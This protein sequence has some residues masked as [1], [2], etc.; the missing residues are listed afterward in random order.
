MY[1]DAFESVL[2]VYSLRLL[3]AF[4]HTLFFTAW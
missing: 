1:F 2:D 4:D 3:S